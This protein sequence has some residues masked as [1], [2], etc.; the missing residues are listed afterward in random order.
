MSFRKDN[1]NARFWRKRVLNNQAS[2]DACGLPLLVLEDEDHWWDFLLHGYLDHHED[3]SR[4]NVSQLS[5]AQM[6]ALHDFLEGELTEEEKQ[7]AMVFIYLKSFL[8]DQ[9]E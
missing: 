6:R 2:L 9:T 3:P 1:H 4:F 7:S 5:P 8:Q